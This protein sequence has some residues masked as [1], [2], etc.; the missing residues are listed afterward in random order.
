MLVSDFY[1]AVKTLKKMQNFQNYT[2]INIHL[3]V[4]KHDDFHK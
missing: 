2:T 4:G 3:I 1:D